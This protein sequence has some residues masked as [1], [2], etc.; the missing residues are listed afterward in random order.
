MVSCWG[1]A[2][3][4]AQEASLSRDSL[5][6]QLFD[7]RH[8]IP[9]PDAVIS[10]LLPVL[11]ELLSRSHQVVCPPHIGPADVLNASFSLLPELHVSLDGFLQVQDCGVLDD[12]HSWI[13]RSQSSG[14][15]TTMARP[16]WKTS[17]ASEC[18]SASSSSSSS[19]CGSGRPEAPATSRAPRSPRVPP[20]HRLSRPG[21]GIPGLPAGKATHGPAFGRGA[22]LPPGPMRN[23]ALGASLPQCTLGVRSRRAYW[24]ADC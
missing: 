18:G 3:P 10:E 1:R 21:P 24:W 8:L 12:N 16:S 20:P 11:C 7:E 4:P 9:V 17:T 15:C 19:S 2:W 14:S 5:L 22:G 6:S 13:G 23:D